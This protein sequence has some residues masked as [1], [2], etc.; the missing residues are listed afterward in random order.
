M[1]MAKSEPPAPAEGATRFQDFDDPT[2][3]ANS[4]WEKHGQFMMSGGGRQQFIWA[5]RGWIA[6]EQLADGVEVTGESNREDEGV[7]APA[8]E[9]DQR[10]ELEKEWMAQ[11]EWLDFT[12][13]LIEVKLRHVPAITDER[14]DKIAAEYADMPQMSVEESIIAAIN[15][16]L[17]ESGVRK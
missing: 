7:A 9:E 15:L 10:A 17:K 13:W 4:W 1:K 3:P 8:G 11:S 12:N 16:A 2:H 5:C 14:I 6:R